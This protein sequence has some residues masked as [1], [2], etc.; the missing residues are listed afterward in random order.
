[1][2][3]APKS[4]NFPEYYIAQGESFSRY[5]PHQNIPDASRPVRPN[6]ADR[7][8]GTEY[9]YISIGAKTYQC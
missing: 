8:R 3:A 4:Q 6:G 2:L 9:I 5:V 7:S 1:M